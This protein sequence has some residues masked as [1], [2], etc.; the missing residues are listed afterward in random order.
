M[1]SKI[2]DF[3]PSE[4]FLIEVKLDRNNEDAA[5]QIFTSALKGNELIPG[6]T[7]TKIYPSVATIEDVNKREAKDKFLAAVNGAIS[8]LNRVKSNIHKELDTE[9][10]GIIQK[11]Y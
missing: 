1:D 2:I 6:L 3:F 4:K 10:F 8:A 7:V 9:N 5:A 11:I